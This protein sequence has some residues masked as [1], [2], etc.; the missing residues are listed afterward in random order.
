[1][2]DEAETETMSAERTSDSTLSA[3]HGRE[4]VNTN[5]FGINTALLEYNDRL[6]ISGSTAFYITGFERSLLTRQTDGTYTSNRRP[7]LRG[8]IVRVNADGTSTLREKNGTVRSFDTNGW[9]QRITDR[10]GNTVTI[11]RSGS[12]IQ[13]IIEPGGRALTFQYSGGGIS[14]ITDPLGRTVRY[15]YEASPPPFGQAQLH[16]VENP[17]G[18]TTTYTYDGRFNLLTITDARGITYLTNTYVSPGAD[19]TRRP[20]D[21]AVETQTLA[22]GSVSRIDYV[23][24]NQMIT[25]ATVTDGR[26]NKT[27]HRFNSFGHEVVMV[28]ALGQQ[29]RMTRDYVTN[30]VN[31]GA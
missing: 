9:L 26:G 22:D 12:Q 19:P 23:V 2:I 29:T 30:R 15:T 17:V 18:G 24:T 28:D 11:L 13:Q 1:M 31:G 6:T 8:L 10:N 7:F 20:L 16:S 5:A 27:A 25:Q 14:Q 21:P 3:P 4:L